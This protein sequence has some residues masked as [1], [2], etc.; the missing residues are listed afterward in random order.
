MSAR[1]QRAAVPILLA[2]CAAG[3][4]VA[5]PGRCL[6]W[7]KCPPP[8]CHHQEGPPRIKFKCGCPRPV[9]PPC[10]SEFFGYYPTCW[11]PWGMVSNCPDIYPPWVP[12]PPP[13][14]PP[15]VYAPLAPYQG[16]PY[17]DGDEVPPELPVPRTAPP[18]DG[19][20]IRPTAM[21]SAGRPRLTRYQTLTPAAYPAVVPAGYY[22]Q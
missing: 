18:D 19:Q 16:V 4:A 11:R 13:G 12:K 8:Y 17:P 15:G 7:G 14:P 3:V 9:C 2:V 1:K 22:G 5:L 6:A 10:D 20:R 21:S